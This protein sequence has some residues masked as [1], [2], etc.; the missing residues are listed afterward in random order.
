[1]KLA[2]QR[3]AILRSSLR[4]S[5]GTLALDD[6]EGAREEF[7]H[8]VVHEEAV[9]EQIMR[10]P[11]TQADSQDSGA[12]GEAAIPIQGV[13]AVPPVAANNRSSPG[14]LAAY[15]SQPFKSYKTNAVGGADRDQLILE[16]LPQVRLIARRIHDRL[17]ESVS[18]DDLIST[19]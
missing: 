5:V 3:Q 7:E 18:L 11:T 12:E 15:A 16:H 14:N 9:D 1:M 13:G 17:P 4:V 6:D 8:E 2:T 19:G 10:R